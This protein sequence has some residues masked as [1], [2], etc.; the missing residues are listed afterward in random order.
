MKVLC[1]EE[2]KEALRYLSEAARIAL[3]STCLRARCGSV[4]VSNSIIIGTGFNSPPGER[5]SQRRCTLEKIVHNQKVTDKT[6]CVHAE[7]RAIMDALSNFPGRIKGSR[8]YFTRIDEKGNPIR[9]GEPYCTICS[10]MALDTG[11]ENF[12][13][14]HNEGIFVYDTEEY[15]DLSYRYGQE[16]NSRFL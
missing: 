3:G 6:C 4:I 1:G 13:L 16:A 15:N 2:E 11:I 5:E 8:L 12:I 14:W 10:K 7:Q 9:S